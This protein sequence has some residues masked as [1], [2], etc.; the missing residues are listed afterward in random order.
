MKKII[1]AFLV[2]T[3]AFAQTD[4]CKCDYIKDYYQLVYEA[5]I[6]YMQNDFDKAYDFLKQ[7]EKNCEILIPGRYEIDMLVEISFKKGLH[8]DALSYIEQALYKGIKI[9]YFETYPNFEG[10]TEVKGWKKLKEK[11]Q[12][13]YDEW[14]S[15]LNLDLRSE[16]AE[17]IEEDQRVRQGKSQYDDEIQEVDDYNEKRFKEILAEFGYPNEQIIGHYNTDEKSVHIGIFAFHIK[18]IEH[19]KPLFLEYVRCGKVPA[20]LYASLIDSHDR[21]RGM[22]TYGIYDNVTPEYIEDFENLDERRIN[23]GLRPYEQQ[24]LY[25]KLDNEEIQKLIEQSKK[26]N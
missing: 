19:F 16:L 17:M 11:S 8:K 3:Y 6:N 18:D 4:D 24:L 15:K 5:E 2:S 12:K 10:I 23:A 1:I 21:R 25:R 9:S 7:A 13:I 20:D 14:Y 22:F 26:Q